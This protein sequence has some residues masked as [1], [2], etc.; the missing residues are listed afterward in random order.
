MDGSMRYVHVQTSEMLGD[1]LR[2]EAADVCTITPG[3]GS[4]ETQPAGATL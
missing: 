1:G 4:P 3:P 2:S